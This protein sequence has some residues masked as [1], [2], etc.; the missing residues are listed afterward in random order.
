MIKMINELNNKKMERIVSYYNKDRK[1]S[2]AS[3]CLVKASRT[4]SEMGDLSREDE[5]YGLIP[6]FFLQ[7]AAYG[8][9]KYTEDQIKLTKIEMNLKAKRDDIALDINEY[10]NNECNQSV[11]AD[12]FR[13]SAYINDEGLKNLEVVWGDADFRALPANKLECLKSLKAV[14]GNL[15][16]SS[17][18]LDNVYVGGNV[19]VTD[20]NKAK[21]LTR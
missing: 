2:T 7:V 19:I 4:F 3:K 11:Y 17:G 9:S 1:N 18:S 20:R 10:L 15:Y 13:Y 21:G 14:L 5:G 12:D 16:L 6:K 8:I